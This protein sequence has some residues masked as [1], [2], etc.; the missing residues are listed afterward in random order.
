MTQGINN[1]T[2]ATEK[3]ISINFTKANTKFGLSL[4]YN[5]KGDD[6]YLYVSKTEIYTFRSKDNKSWYNFCLGS[7]SQNFTR[8]EQSGISFNGT[9]FDF[10]VDHSSIK[11]KTFLVFTNI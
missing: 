3:G 6:S 10:S 5:G 8:D 9:V 1:S 11:K 2:G 4:I 7:V